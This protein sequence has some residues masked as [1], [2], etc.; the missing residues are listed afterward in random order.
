[1]PVEQLRAAIHAGKEGRGGWLE[2]AVLEP[3][4]RDEVHR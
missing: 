3:D 2:L 4:M 1:M